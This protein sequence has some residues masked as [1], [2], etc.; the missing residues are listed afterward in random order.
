MMGVITVHSDLQPNL[1]RIVCAESG[2]CRVCGQK[3]ETMEHFLYK[4]D[5]TNI[6]GQTWRKLENY[7]EEIGIEQI[8]QSFGLQQ[9]KRIIDSLK[10]FGKE[11]G[12]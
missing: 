8:L 5:K 3:S 9:V 6:P 12:C 7:I 11:H 10:W 1:N 4:F 2:E